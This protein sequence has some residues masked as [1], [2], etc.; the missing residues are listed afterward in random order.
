MLQ[1]NLAAQVKCANWTL[2]D[3]AG[4]GAGGCSGGCGCIGVP[5]AP[6]PT[7]GSVGPDGSVPLN[8]PC[9]AP[10]GCGDP[11]DG[12][13]PPKE[14]CGKPA[15]FC[16]PEEGCCDPNA[17][18]PKDGGVPEASCCNA[19]KLPGGSADAGV[20]K[21][22]DGEDPGEAEPNSG[23]GLNSSGFETQGATSCFTIHSDEGGWSPI[24]GAGVTDGFGPCNGLGAPSTT[25]HDDPGT[26][27][28]GTG[29]LSA[30]SVLSPSPV[31]F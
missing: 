22:G 27:A 6:I 20:P 21:E 13:E 25:P 19:P 8:A 9:S 16:E 30:V 12:C 10:G 18:A 2:V 4:G 26:G 31:R 29:G 7:L 28:P 24:A 3:E 11:K 1:V 5:K 14:D 17:E 23:F 15:E